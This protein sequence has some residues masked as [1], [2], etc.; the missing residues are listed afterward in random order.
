MADVLLIA[1]A[2]LQQILKTRMNQP[3]NQAQQE[4]IRNTRSTIN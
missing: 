3:D 1:T 2:N 4:L